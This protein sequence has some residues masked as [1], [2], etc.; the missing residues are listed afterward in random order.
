[1]DAGELEPWMILNTT[2]NMESCLLLNP[3]P[4]VLEDMWGQ[5]G[6]DIPP[7]S[8]A[9]TEQQYTT[10]TAPEVGLGRTEGVI[11]EPKN[12][13]KVGAVQPE[14]PLADYMW[15]QL[16]L[17]S[18]PASGSWGEQQYASAASPEVGIVGSDGSIRH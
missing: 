15:G 14:I 16:V 13:T 2:A 12:G 1:M 4:S 3:P 17:D 9:W 11:S 6:L 7:A 18:P 8:G 10:A 5:L